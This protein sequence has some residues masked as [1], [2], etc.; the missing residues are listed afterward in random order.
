VFRLKKTLDK[1]NSSPLNSLDR[2]SLNKEWKLRGDYPGGEETLLLKIKQLQIETGFS[3]LAL[4]VCVLRG[5]ETAQAISDFLNPRLENLTSPLLLKDMDRAVE[6]IV[7][8]RN[9]KQKLRLF[10]DY[11]VDGTAGAALLTWIFREFSIPC[12]VRQPNR[13]TDG[14]GLNV[15]AIE[16]AYQ[17]GVQVLITIDCGITSFEALE[18]A[19]EL[20]I[21]VI[22]LDHHQVDPKR[23]LPPAVAIVN[24]QRED[25][26]SGLK[27]LCGCGVAFYLGMA[28]RSFGKANG[29]FLNGK[30]PNLRKHLDLVVI[31]TAADQVPLTGDNRILVSHGLQVL[32]FTS[33]PGVKALMQ[34]AGIASKNLSPSHLGFALGPR[35]NASGRMAEANEAFKL[36]STENILEAESLA[37]ELERLNKQRQELQ[38]TIWDDVRGQVERGIQKGLFKNAVVV[39]SP[40]WHEGVIGIVASKVTEAFHR[41]AI[42]ISFNGEKAKGSV[43]SYRNKNVLEALRNCHS[44]LSSYGGHHCAAGLSLEVANFEF[45]QSAFDQA[46][47]SQHDDHDQKEKITFYLEGECELKD[48]DLKTLHELERLAPF[49]NGNPEPQFQMKA[50]IFELQSI[51]GRHLKLFLGALDEDSSQPTINS[52]TQPMVPLIE[53]IWFNAAE[54]K[55]NLQGFQETEWEWLGVP[56]LNRFR[57]QTKP[58]FRIRDC[59]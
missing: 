35:I 19:R 42:V 11:D 47:A 57:G 41:P 45:F 4:R 51:K 27:Q 53:A 14:Y 34:V 23:G 30:I 48:F 29:W 26:E 56:E 12:D 2:L 25:C 46:I 18:K 39:G 10:S 54:G 15:R 6:R 13:F 38:N 33:K 5:L 1:L 9:E 37:Q 50:K 59:R 20:G 31:A 7:H 21:D 17:D 40:D 49:G 43:R 22:I 16:E 28:L 8:V 58:S 55:K 3:F 44:L 32:K 52:S 24:P 36:L